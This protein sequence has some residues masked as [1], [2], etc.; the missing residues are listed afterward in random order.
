MT[1]RELGFNEWF[2]ARA[3]GL[4]PEGCGIARV[5]AVDR[6]SCLISS[7]EGVV[8]A[9]S[10]GR[11][12]FQADGPAGLPCVGDWVV[13]RHHGDAA[14]IHAVLPRKSF[15]RRAA[16][17]A[18]GGAARGVQMI[19]ANIDAAFLVQS[20]GF[21]FNPSRLERYL[22]MAADGGVEP[23]V[24]LAK[25]DLAGPEEL[26]RMLAVLRSV[27]AARVIALSC[28]SGQGFAELEQELSPGRTCCLLGS[29]GVG[30]TTLINRLLGRE[31]LATG[32]VSGT[33]E[34][35]HTTTRR[36]LVVLDRGA[37]LV[38]TPGMRELGVV[39]A[40]EET[41]AGFAEITALA[42]HCRYADCRHG[43]EPGCA[44]Q[45]A[46]ERGALPAGRLANYLKLRAEA[47]F[48]SLSQLERRKKDKDFGRF[49]KT[50][51]KDLRR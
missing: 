14:V 31:A 44:V 27:A 47:E 45:A 25:A 15:L 8:P 18:P 3:A 39:G 11:L 36:Q 35:T 23:V 1:L 30:K 10:A 46:V 42:E 43:G 38:D 26:E 50:A 16:P 7:G 21:D 29:S 40:G 34:G 5:M 48:Q 32:A 33:G 41:G 13:A 12:L 19:A 17:G 4:C 2:E 6:G 37:L 24:L 9:E 28:V 51:K 49:M 20:C 22:M